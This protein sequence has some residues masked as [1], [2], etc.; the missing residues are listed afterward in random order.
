MKNV[1]VIGLGVMGTALARI[2]LQNGFK[3]TVWNRSLDKAET[4][5]DEGATV[6]GSCNEAI[7][8]NPT[9]LVC[10]KTHADTKELLESAQSLE[11][12]N[13]IELS[14]GSAPEAE[15]LYQ[16][17]EEEKATLY[18]GQDDEL[19]SAVNKTWHYMEEFDAPLGI[20]DDPH[21]DLPDMNRHFKGWIKNVRIYDY[22][23]SQ[24]EIET[25]FNK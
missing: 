13:I 19:I 20:G 12:K 2:L 3:V 11:G 16:W 10:I 15:S 14:T 22:A 5:K 25:V 21:P 8:A 23:L 7:S 18:L 9:I 4:L 1:T 17:L 6:A 24:H